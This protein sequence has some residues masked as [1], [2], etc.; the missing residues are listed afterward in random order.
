M[1]RKLMGVAGFGSWVA[2]CRPQMYKNVEPGVPPW[3]SELRTVHFTAAAQVTAVAWVQ[4]MAQELLNAMGV[5]K[6][7]V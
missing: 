5:V 3:P 1:I 6:K 7:K 4:A 2:V